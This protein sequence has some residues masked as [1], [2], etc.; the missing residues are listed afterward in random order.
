MLTM[1]CSGDPCETKFRC[2]DPR[3]SPYRTGAARHKGLEFLM[4]A[5][6]RKVVWRKGP[7][8]LHS[9]GPR[10]ATQSRAFHSTAC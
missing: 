3:M 7:T 6:A 5:P 10:S 2:E 8:C 9:T 4:T 1:S